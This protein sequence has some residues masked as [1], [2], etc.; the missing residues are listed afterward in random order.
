M[1][2]KQSVK[3]AKRRLYFELIVCPT[4][5]LTDNEVDI[6]YALA[7]DRDIHDIL[8]KSKEYSG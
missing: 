4:N 1:V 8:R 3:E 7:K 6:A 5:Q 2:Q